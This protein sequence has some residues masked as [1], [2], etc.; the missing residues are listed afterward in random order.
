MGVVNVVS[1]DVGYGVYTGH[2]MRGV[3]LAKLLD[4]WH[5][6]HGHLYSGQIMHVNESHMGEYTDGLRHL[7]ME[8]VEWVEDGPEGHFI[9]P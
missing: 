4:F 9:S 7:V 8:G 2:H 1:H 3:V 6:G 5:I